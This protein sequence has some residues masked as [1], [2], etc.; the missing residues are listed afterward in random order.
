V[1]LNAQSRTFHFIF[2]VRGFRI[3][4][5]RVVERVRVELERDLVEDDLVEDRDPPDD[6]L[7]PPPDL[8]PV[9][10][11]CEQEIR[12]HRTRISRFIVLLLFDLDA[13]PMRSR[14]TN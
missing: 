2:L 12:I 3:P 11:P 7:D 9:A 14:E 6:D 1:R 10:K 13:A 4:E 8:D 5:E